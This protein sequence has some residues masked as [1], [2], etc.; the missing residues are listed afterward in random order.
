MK[1]VNLNKVRKARAKVKK[2]AEADANALKCGR[3][4]ARKAAEDSAVSKLA[5]HIEAHK[6]EE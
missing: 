3:S 2:A 5:R 6:R 4:K 1:P